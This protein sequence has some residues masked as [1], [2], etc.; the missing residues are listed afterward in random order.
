MKKMDIQ[1]DEDEEYDPPLH[2]PKLKSVREALTVED[3]LIVFTEFHGNEELVSSANHISALLTT[4]H[5]NVLK[6]ST[7][8]SFNC[9][10]Y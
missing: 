5:A 8:D 6:Q 10:I 4:M 2:H 1:Y 9:T 7:L 3:D